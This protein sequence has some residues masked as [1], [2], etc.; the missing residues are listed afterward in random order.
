M[1]C[2]RGVNARKTEEKAS[3]QYDHNRSCNI[4]G[5][6]TRILQSATPTKR[7]VAGEVLVVFAQLSLDRLLGGLPSSEPGR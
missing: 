2:K 5:P 3:R 4:H 1:A 7:S 6:V